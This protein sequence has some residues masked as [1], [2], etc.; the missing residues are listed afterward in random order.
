MGAQIGVLAVRRSILINAP[1]E[2]IWQEFESYERMKAW[3]G[4]GHR[5]VAYEPR[6][7][8]QVRME[9]EH[10][11]ATLRY[12]G[13]I[14]VFEPA[15]EVTWDND[16]DGAGWDAPTMITI[17][18]T[19]TLGGTL[20]ELFHH[21]IERVGAHAADQHQGFESGWGMNHLSALRA[22]VEG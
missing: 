15:R 3:F 21:A 12:G 5:L 7:G 19:P 1:P 17:R 8:G 14:T 16:T 10:E 2:R 4:L 6:V 9:V 20:V 22:I 18:L 13:P 11:G